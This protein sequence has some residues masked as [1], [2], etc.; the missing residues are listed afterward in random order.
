MCSDTPFVLLRELL[1]K[2]RLVEG[3]LLPLVEDSDVPRAKVLDFKLR[4]RLASLESMS[5]AQL[6]EALHDR[7]LPYSVEEPRE[8]LMARVLFADF[9]QVLYGGVQ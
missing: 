3:L 1:E 5:S 9:G 6:R 8:M 2:T 4:W 7:K